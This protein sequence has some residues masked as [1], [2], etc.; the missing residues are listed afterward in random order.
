[1]VNTGCFLPHTNLALP[2]FCHE[3]WNGK[4]K[5]TYL[6][7]GHIMSRL[8]HFKSAWVDGL[9]GERQPRGVD[10]DGRSVFKNDFLQFFDRVVTMAAMY[11]LSGRWPGTRAPHVLWV[12]TATSEKP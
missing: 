6:A 1:V 12:H 2:P 7:P 3:D 4:V 10:L 11:R 9:P 8:V 5:R